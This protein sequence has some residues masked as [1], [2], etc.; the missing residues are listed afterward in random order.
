MKKLILG[1]LVIFLFTACNEQPQEPTLVIGEVDLGAIAADYPK[2]DG[3]TSAHPLQTTIACYIL[4][5]EC[6]WWEEDGFLFD[7]TRRYLPKM[8][9]AEE[10]A[11]LANQVFG[12]N[13]SGTHGA[14]VNL[15]EGEADIILVAREPSEDELRDAEREGIVLDVQPVALDAF[16]FIVN[17][18]NPLE[19]LELDT[20]RDIYTGKITYW[21][22]LGIVLG[23]DNDPTE[24][25]HTYSRNKNSGSQEL[26][27]KLVMRGEEMVD[28]PDMM[29]LPTM[30][31][32]F[33]AISVDI[34]GIGYSVYFYTEFMVLGE[35]VKMIGV[36]GVMPTYETIGDQSYPLTTEVYV[37]IRQDTPTG[38][39]A[40]MLRDWLLGD[41][42]QAVVGESG[43]VPVR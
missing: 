12:I 40:R 7:S 25:I 2:V 34:L 20:I 3:S 10:D 24:P 6:E 18:D 30:F 9:V 21:E 33:N 35:Y 1:L 4:E 19:S 41:E 27:E 23:F 28:A 16:V 43:Y 8:S 31:A 15:I 38:S 22:E 36:D 37:V 13:H 11:D 14:Y 26:M 42:G 32:P 17:E 29:A 39:T 5:V